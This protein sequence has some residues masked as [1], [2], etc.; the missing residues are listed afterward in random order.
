M[1]VR[2]SCRNALS[3]YHRE[4]V[5]GENPFDV[6]PYPYP[7]LMRFVPPFK[8]VWAHVAALPPVTRAYGVLLTVGR[9]RVEDCLEKPVV[10]DGGLRRDGHVVPLTTQAAEWL[11]AWRRPRS[12]KDVRTALGP[13][14]VSEM[15]ASVVAALQA[16]GVPERTIMMVYGR[17]SAM[18]YCVADRPLGY[19]R[20]DLLAGDA[21][22]G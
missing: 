20:T 17:Q 8:E 15:H 18:K 5:G 19:F 11:S 12:A 22:R 10:V 13:Y 3:Q 2:Q 21:L 14:S 1:P 9:L 4:Y 6:Q 7:L 16:R